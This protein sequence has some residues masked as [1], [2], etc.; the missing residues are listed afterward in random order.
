MSKSLPVLKILFF[1]SSFLKLSP[2]LLSIL[3]LSVLSTSAA[4]IEE[5]IY[6]VIE[7]SGNFELRVYDPKI[8]AEV[9]VTGSLKEASSKGF[10][11][12][13][14][15]IFGKNTSRTS[16]NSDIDNNEKIKMTAPVT[17][18]SA[19]PKT[20]KINMTSPVSMKQTGEKWLM[21]F[22][23]PS[24]YTLATLPKPNNSA[25]TIRKIN[26]AKYAVHRFSGLADKAKADEKT[27]E[28]ERWLKSKNIKATGNPELAR[29]NPPWTLP[30]LR[31]NEV[32]VKY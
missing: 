28:L 10:K 20:E 23:M 19:T 6:R 8:I 3:F 2:S 18:K 7:T 11:L 9:E 27:A 12:I 30:F 17:M 25:V 13:A 1:K 15:Y 5:P 31:R 16:I 32:M 22:V 14:G 24:K 29:Y 26:G 21:H 4:A